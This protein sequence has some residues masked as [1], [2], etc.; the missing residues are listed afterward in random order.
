MVAAAALLLTASLQIPRTLRAHFGDVPAPP[1]SYYRPGVPLEAISYTKQPVS[2]EP[3]AD[4]A[5]ETPRQAGKKATQPRIIHSGKI[6]LAVLNRPDDSQ[7]SSSSQ[8]ASVLHI[9]QLPAQNK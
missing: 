8:S 7:N 9:T 4:N 5:D 3:Q 1:P 6:A 2:A